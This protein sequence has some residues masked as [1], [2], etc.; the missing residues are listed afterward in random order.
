MINLKTKYMGIELDNPIIIGASNM[1]KDL[2]K[3]KKA[4]EL[5]VAAVVYKSLFE[6]QIQLERLQIDEKLTEFNDI[7]AEMLTTQPDIIY[8]GSDN[9]LFNLRKTKESLSIPVIAS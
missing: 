9:H 5:G 1:S 3:L 4:E 6:E 7:N 2:D 8:E